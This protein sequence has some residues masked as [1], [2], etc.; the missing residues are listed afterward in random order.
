MSYSFSVEEK[1]NRDIAKRL[2]NLDTVTN[3]PL[4]VSASD[5]LDAAEQAQC[6]CSPKERESGHK[7]GCWFPALQYAIAKAKG[8]RQ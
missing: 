4:T 8:Q 6:D 3:D 7:V 5:L 2:R 1:L